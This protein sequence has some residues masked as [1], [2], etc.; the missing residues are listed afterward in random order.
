MTVDVRRFLR[1]V[2]TRQDDGLT[3]ANEAID[4]IVQIEKGKTHSPYVVGGMAVKPVTFVT[5]LN[6]LIGSDGL[7][8]SKIEAIKALRL[9]TGCGLKEAKTAVEELEVTL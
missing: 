3:L 4:L 7:R 1:K 9:E 8:Q 2:A 6:R 5:I